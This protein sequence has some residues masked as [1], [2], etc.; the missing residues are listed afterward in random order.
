MVGRSA[1]SC[2]RWSSSSN[3]FLALENSPILLPRLRAKVGSFL[4]P[5]RINTK[6]AMMMSSGVP[7]GPKP[8]MIGVFMIGF[9]VLLTVA[10]NRD[11][12]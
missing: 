8:A 6:T 11:F 4:A 2:A 7:S 12:H 3:S 5:K 1:S 10:C 9:I